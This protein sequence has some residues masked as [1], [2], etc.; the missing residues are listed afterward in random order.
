M[1]VIESSRFVENSTNFTTKTFG[2]KSKNLSHIIH[3]IRDQIYSDKILA[4]IREYSCN[5]YDANV[6]NGKADEPIVVTLPSVMNPEFKVRDFGGGLSDKDIEEIFISYGE[7]TKRNTNDAIGTLGIGAKSGFAYG[8]NFIVTSYNN[9]IKTVYDC[10]LDKTNVGS[11]LTLLSVPMGKND[12]EGIEITINVKKD[13]VEEFRKKAIEFYKWWNVKPTVVGFNADELKQD[14]KKVLFSGTD[15]SIY[16]SPQRGYYGNYNDSP[17]AYALMGNIA[18]PIDWKNVRLSTKDKINEAII[19]Y[20]KHC[21]IVIRFPIGE[22]QFAPSREALQ[23]TDH[24]QAGLLKKLH[25]IMS[26][27]EDVIQAKFTDCKT[28]WEAKSLFG[29]L[30][31]YN[32][33]YGNLADLKSYFTTK[34]LKWNKLVINSADINNFDHYD[35]Q[36]G[37]NVAGHARDA[38]GNY[39]NHIEV[40]DAYHDRGTMIKSSK[41][42]EIVCSKESLVMLYDVTKHNFKRKACKYLFGKNPTVKRIYVLDFQGKTSLHD[43]CFKKQN[44]DLIPM[45]K[46]SDIMEDVKKSII[47]IRNGN[48]TVAKRVSTPNIRQGKYVVVESNTYYNHYSSRNTYNNCWKNDDKI[49]IKNGKGCYVELHQN[50][51]RWGRTEESFSA[52][53]QVCN[54]VKQFAKLGLIDEVKHIYGFGPR[55]LESKGF[56]SKNWVRVETLISHAMKQIAP[57]KTLKY[58]LAF[59]QIAKMAKHSTPHKTF[60]ENV[61]KKITDKNN[62]LVKF[63]NLIGKFEGELS[64]SVVKM[65]GDTDYKNEMKEIESLVSQINNQYPMLRLTRGFVDGYATLTNEWKF[66][67][68]YINQIDA[69]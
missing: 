27:I 55:I 37:Y 52:V 26:E 17:H 69:K 23:Y 65:I 22:I 3:I 48:R 6:M 32:Y 68:D 2:I 35:I 1:K 53:Q 50:H 19:D 29:E 14:E 28:L 30:F 54:L 39:R 21:Q 49:D 12:K 43:D 47:R 66:T 31:G 44:L 9:G 58:K 41:T 18:Y 40:L 25:V 46:Y 59:T 13:D 15:W 56:N 11:C 36:N 33:G 34:G 63:E 51:L 60:L 20:I 24:T 62:P 45:V 5:A 38:Q 8:D 67:T 10:V 57:N 16:A 4:V 61:C 7:S 42:D 64:E